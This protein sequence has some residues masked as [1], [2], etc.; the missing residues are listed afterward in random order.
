MPKRRGRSVNI[1]L[2]RETRTIQRNIP[3]AVGA[4]GA[5][6]LQKVLYNRLSASFPVI[7]DNKELVAAA[8]ILVGLFG[9]QLVPS[10]SEVFDGVLIAGLVDLVGALML[11][12]GIDIV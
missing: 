8:P 4:V 1:N 6:F 2:T 11:R 9:R 3:E 7:R 5:I 12:F 10:Q